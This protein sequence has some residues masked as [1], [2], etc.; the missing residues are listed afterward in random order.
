MGDVTGEG[1]LPEFS[2]CRCG[3]AASL[4]RRIFSRAMQCCPNSSV[5]DPVAVGSDTD[6]AQDVVC[7]MPCSI[8]LRWPPTCT[9]PGRRL[10][11]GGDVGKQALQLLHPFNV[12]GSVQIVRGVHLGGVEAASQ[13]RRQGKAAPEDF[14]WYTR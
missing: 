5:A 10:H 13:L 11:L 7:A 1:A 14:K 3:A 2:E 6:A 12:P 9:L 4:K 8:P